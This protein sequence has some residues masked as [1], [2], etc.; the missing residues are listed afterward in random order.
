MCSQP[1]RA[2]PAD[3]WTAKVPHELDRDSSILLRGNK[4]G[5]EFLSSAAG[6]HHRDTFLFFPCRYVLQDGS[7]YMR[8]M[9]QIA[10]EKLKARH[11]R[12]ALEEVEEDLRLSLHL[13][14]EE[15][16]V[17]DAIPDQQLDFKQLLIRYKG[18]VL[19]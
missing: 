13:Q 2:Q 15:E 8:S 9:K 12:T 11:N 10:K 5:G 18:T 1:N 6:T 3:S 17:K 7:P 14:D 19:T 4:M 16:S